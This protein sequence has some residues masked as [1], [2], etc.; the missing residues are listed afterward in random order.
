VP[1]RVLKEVLSSLLVSL[2]SVSPY[3][4]AVQCASDTHFCKRQTTCHMLCECL[5]VRLHLPILESPEFSRAGLGLGLS[6]DQSTL[7]SVAID[8]YI[9]HKCGKGG[10]RASLIGSGNLPPSESS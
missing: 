9:I 1:F 3:L 5:L 2:N 7:L 6:A 10:S 8:E 4:A